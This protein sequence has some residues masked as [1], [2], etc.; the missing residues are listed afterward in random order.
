[1]AKTKLPLPPPPA[2]GSW[3]PRLQWPVL[4]IW[5]ALVAVFTLSAFAGWSGGGESWAS[6]PRFLRFLAWMPVLFLAVFA[7]LYLSTRRAAHRNQEGID[8]LAS[9]ELEAAAIVFRDV[10]RRSRHAVPGAF[11]LGLTLLRLA[12]VRGAL[13]AFAAAERA[14]GR[15]GR[16]LLAAA[17]AGDLALCYALLGELDAAEAWA[18]EARRRVQRPG[19]PSR[20][21]VVAEAVALDRRGHDEAAARRLA[22]RW[23]EL[24]LTTSADLMRGLR[25]VRA[26]VLER[27]GGTPGEVEALLA[28]ARPFRRGEYAWLYAGWKE[29]E[30]WAA[31]KGFVAA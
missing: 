16:G 6:D 21:H 2:R 10:A 24:E 5:L 7:G 1:M 30:V 25:L 19:H 4:A 31:V 9:G 22:E 14:G 12:D 27:A 28:G 29:L 15:R 3:L 23:G 13:A 8:R 17:V 11:N 18:L 26:Y 20:L